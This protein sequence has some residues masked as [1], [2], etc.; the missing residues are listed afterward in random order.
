MTVPI[1]ALYAGILGLLITALAIN[2]TV[3]RA[4]LKVDIGDGGNAQM[5][6]MIRVHANAVEYVPLG[7]LLL[8]LYEL[9]QGWPAV[10]H[11]AGIALV[12][13]R[14][15]HVAGLWN[16]AGLSFGRGAGVTLTWITIAALAVLNLWQIR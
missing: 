8:G 1:T 10:L 3:H 12:V 6:R 15:L 11:A 4:K 2:V 14:V 13:G 7:L 5:L 16:T 9:D